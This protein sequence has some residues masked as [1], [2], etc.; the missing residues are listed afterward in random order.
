MND[1]SIFKLCDYIGH[2]LPLLVR[3]GLNVVSTVSSNNGLRILIIVISSLC[4]L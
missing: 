2:R 3:C 1:D 4:R